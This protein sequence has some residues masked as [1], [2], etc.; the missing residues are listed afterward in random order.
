MTS[1]RAGR[2]QDV[3]SAGG[4]MDW[5]SLREATGLSAYTLDKALE[6]LTEDG[7]VTLEDG[8]YTA[9][10]IPRQRHHWTNVRPTGPPKGHDR[11]TE[12][13]DEM[14]KLLILTGSEEIR[15][16][17]EKEMMRRCR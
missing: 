9:R 5:A 3:L 6:S 15:E 10:R 12:A 16:R 7:L 8:M 2:V 14:L 17:A 13:S 1:P 4:P 11:I